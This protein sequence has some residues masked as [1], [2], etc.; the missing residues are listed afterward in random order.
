MDV[1]FVLRFGDR[2]LLRCTNRQHRARR[3][4]HDS[5]G[6][7][8]QHHTVISSPAMCSNDDQISLA[9]LRI[10][11][12]AVRGCSLVHHV[13]R[14]SWIMAVGLQECIDS[15]LGALVQGPAELGVVARRGNIIRKGIS[16]NLDDVLGDQLR[17]IMLGERLCIKIRPNGELREI[18]GAKD[19]FDF[20]HDRIPADLWVHIP[21]VGDY[22]IT[23]GPP[24]GSFFFKRKA[25]KN[26]I[27][28][29]TQR[30]MKVSMYA[31]VAAWPCRD[32]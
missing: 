23:C 28:D 27:P 12:N 9:G 8:S 2:L 1:L 17:S 32:W 4:A 19:D 21:S 22:S 29:N 25:R 7:R 15:L 11:Q 24:P 30:T 18:Y 5:I 13:F 14:V 3:S 16:G 10:R 26:M 20:Q 31:R 6:H